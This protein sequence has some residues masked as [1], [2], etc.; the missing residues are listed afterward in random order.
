M[1]LE[2]ASDQA[3]GT[4]HGHALVD[5]SKPPLEGMTNAALVGFTVHGLQLADPASAY[6]PICVKHDVQR[7]VAALL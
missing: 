2:R 4:Y 6:S 7:P 1:L 3:K 5:P